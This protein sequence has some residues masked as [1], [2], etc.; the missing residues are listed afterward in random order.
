MPRICF[1]VNNAGSV[2][3]SKKLISRKLCLHFYIASFSCR[4]RKS[5]SPDM[6]TVI[7]LLI[8]EQ[9]LSVELQMNEQTCLT[10][11]GS[12]RHIDFNAI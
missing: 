12:P 5:L 7:L 4:E 8:M 2:S 1:T 11:L 10:F 3:K 6:R 9:A